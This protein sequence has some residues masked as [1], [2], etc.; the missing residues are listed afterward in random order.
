[1]VV[2]TY[3]GLVDGEPPTCTWCHEMETSV[4][5]KETVALVRKVLMRQT[6]EVLT[7]EIPSHR[8]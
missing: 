7:F 3:E 6:E 8:A 5:V 2:A 1:M 4:V